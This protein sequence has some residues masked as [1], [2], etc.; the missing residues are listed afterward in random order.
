MDGTNDHER[1]TIDRVDK[2]NNRQTDG[3]DRDCVVS[4]LKNISASMALIRYG[5]FSEGG[6]KVLRS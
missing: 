2:S 1:A 3:R 5:E 4:G 6:R